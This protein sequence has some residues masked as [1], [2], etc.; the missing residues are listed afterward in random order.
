MRHQE[1]EGTLHFYRALEE[2][3]QAD[4]ALKKKIAAQIDASVPQQESV[5][6]VESDIVEAHLDRLSEGKAEAEGENQRINDGI[7]QIERGAVDMFERGQSFQG[8]AKGMRVDTV[9]YI[10]KL[11]T[12]LCRGARP[13]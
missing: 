2:A 4:D 12:E 10:H 13:D 9:E 6:P 11:R 1:S 3:N 5:M 8:C 7:K